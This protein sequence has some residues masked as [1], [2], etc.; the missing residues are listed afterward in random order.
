MAKR[1]RAADIA[2]NLAGWMGETPAAG[3]GGD[4]GAASSPATTG[5][6]AAEPT[7]A[8]GGRRPM[9]AVYLEPAEAAELE[10]RAAAEDRS[11]SYVARQAIR[12]WLGMA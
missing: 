12:A 8:K 11:V 7:P 2:A 9:I 3:D 10:A 6:A 1:T 4:A 5:P